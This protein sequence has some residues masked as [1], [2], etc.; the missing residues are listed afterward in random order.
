MSRRYEQ[1]SELRLMAGFIRWIQR[2]AIDLDLMSYDEVE[3]YAR[4]YLKAGG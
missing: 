4:S 2:Q 3:H 1:V